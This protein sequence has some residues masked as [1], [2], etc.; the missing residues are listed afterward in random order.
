M[1][2]LPAVYGAVT[3][4]FL[5]PFSARAHT[6]CS[7][8]S[9]FSPASA[10]DFDHVGAAAR[11]KR[12]VL[13]RGRC[14]ERRDPRCARDSR[15]SRRRR[16]LPI[17]RSCSSVLT[18]ALAIA[19]PPLVG[20]LGVGQHAALSATI[21][22]ALLAQSR[23]CRGSGRRRSRLGRTV[24]PAA[25]QVESARPA[26]ARSPAIRSASSSRA[27]KRSVQWRSVSA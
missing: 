25:R 1:I 3:G 14:L 12:G 19:S 27:S 20:W 23:A 22:L 5:A 16:Y 17:L 8:S 18:T 4:Y 6:C 2:A 24:V 7:R 26:R 9:G 21:R 15:R 11:A 13:R 10:P